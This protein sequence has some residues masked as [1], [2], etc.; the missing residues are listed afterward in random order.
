MTS[1]KYDV[2]SIARVHQYYLKHVNDKKSNN[3]DKKTLRDSH[4]QPVLITLYMTKMSYFQLNV[5]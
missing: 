1:E 3:I 2:K 5:K 4:H